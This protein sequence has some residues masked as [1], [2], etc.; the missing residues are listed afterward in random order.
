V[1]WEHAFAKWFGIPAL[2]AW[3]AACGWMIARGLGA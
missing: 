3:F 2:I 1:R